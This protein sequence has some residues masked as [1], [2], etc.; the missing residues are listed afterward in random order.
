MEL[1][2]LFSLRLISVIAEQ[3]D[4]KNLYVSSDEAVDFHKKLYKYSNVSFVRNAR[5]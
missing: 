2:D 4:H 1:K 5:I 3:V